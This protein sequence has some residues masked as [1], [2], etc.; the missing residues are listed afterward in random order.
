MS[1]LTLVAKTYRLNVQRGHPATKLLQKQNVATAWEIILIVVVEFHT[2]E[3]D[4][5][6]FNISSIVQNLKKSHQVFI[7]QSKSTSKNNFVI[8]MTSP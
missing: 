2:Y 8:L 6:I 7:Y 1:Q 3:T 5:A 4:I